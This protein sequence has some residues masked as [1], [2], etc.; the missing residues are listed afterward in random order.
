MLFAPLLGVDHRCQVSGSPIQL[1]LCFPLFN[2]CK[3]PPRTTI[4]RLKFNN[5]GVWGVYVSFV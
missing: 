5:E 2:L 1:H 4:Y 3:V